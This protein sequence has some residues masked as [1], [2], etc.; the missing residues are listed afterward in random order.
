MNQS[1]QTPFVEF[2]TTIGNF[3]IELYWNHAPKTCK[4]IAELSKNGYYNNCIFHRVIRDF[5]IQTGDP[6]GTGK[7]GNSIYG[8]QFEDEIT[9]ELH[10]TGAGICSMANSG[11]NTNTSQFFITLNVTQWLDGKHTIFARVADGMDAVKRIGMMDTDA[12]DKPISQISIL[13]TK[14]LS[15]L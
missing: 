12:T 10:H 14:W 7:C 4:N 6:T 1:N 8:G 11:P 2:E 3:V 9:S 5:M 15:K 13:R